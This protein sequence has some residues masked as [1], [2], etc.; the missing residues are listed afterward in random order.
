G[1]DRH[2]WGRYLHPCRGFLRDARVCSAIPV[3]VSNEGHDHGEADDPCGALYPRLDVPGVG[4]HLRALPPQHHPAAE[5]EPDARP[6]EVTLE[7][8]EQGIEPEPYGPT[9]REPVEQHD[10]H[11]EYCDWPHRLHLHVVLHQRWPANVPQYVWHVVPA[12]TAP[13]SKVDNV[14]A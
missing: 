14:T 7:Q 6:D 8:G 10:A 12:R 4:D 2:F 5:A 11:Q 1:L 3:K 13:A 9:Q